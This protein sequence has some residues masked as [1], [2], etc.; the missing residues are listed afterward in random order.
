[1]L[2]IKIFGIFC[3]LLIICCSTVLSQ[4][5]QTKSLNIP[6]F[7][8]QTSAGVN[9]PLFDL[10]GNWPSDMSDNPIPFFM[11]NPG[12]NF[13]VSSKLYPTKRNW[14][15]IAAISLNLFSAN[16][17]KDTTFPTGQGLFKSYSINIL[18]GAV[19]FEYRFLFKNFKPFIN[20]RL[21]A[22]YFWGKANRN[23]N[24]LVMDETK[25]YGMI[26]GVGFDI[27]INKKLGIIA[28]SDFS[29]YNLLGRESGRTSYSGDY[30]IIDAPAGGSDGRIMSSAN[31]YLG[32]AFYLK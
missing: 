21:T 3:L 1:M 32:L 17:L 8:I 11:E 4:K 6:S 28:G 7:I 24:T 2:K 27:R 14:G 12:F 23:G 29:I 25:R 19:G 31:V 26:A 22:N 30:A 16:D 9:I 20:I 5:N 18:S 10:G 13:G 15:V